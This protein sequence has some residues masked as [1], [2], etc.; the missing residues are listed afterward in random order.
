MIISSL[1][2]A[3][4]AVAVIA[5]F[6]LRSAA[7]SDAVFASALAEAP[8][9]LATL[10]QLK[11]KP[12]KPAAPKIKAPSAPEAVW[13]KVLE[14]V[15]TEGKYKPEAEQLPGMFTIEDL[16]GDPKADHTKNVVTVAGMLNDEEQFQALGAMLVVQE[17]KLDAKDGN[18]HV[19]MWIF[20]TDIY[21]DVSNAAHGAM[22]QSPDGKTLSQTPDKLSPSDPK[23][24]AQY[25]A[26][27]KY[28]AER[29][30]K[31]A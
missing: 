19:D 2:R 24:Q 13:Q 7:Q 1:R 17:F 10:A 29:K 8:A 26:M 18:W 20:Q 28:W 4:L 12:Q 6:S 14:A 3:G 5:S 25:D 16:T 22:I 30:P 21:G 27:L 15:K 31:G 9:G 23:I 11:A